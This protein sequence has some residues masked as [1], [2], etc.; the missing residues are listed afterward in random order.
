MLRNKL[1]ASPVYAGILIGLC[2]SGSPH[3]VGSSAVP[4]KH[5]ATAAYRQF[6]FFIG[7]WETYDVTDSVKSV[8]RNHVSRM[9]DGC[10]VR[11]VYTQ[12]DGLQGESFSTYDSSRRLWHQSWV[13]NHGSL[14]LMD[15]GLNGANM[16]FTGTV[17][18]SAGSK[19]LIR[20][21][22]FPK[23]GSVRETAVRS[24][25]NGKSWQPV[26]DIVFRPHSRLNSH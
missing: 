17:V 11:E 19:S 4:T 10:A 24:T 20:V 26:F 22:W 7:D 23:H 3:R 6:D 25:D 1:L 15:G 8:A 13:T 14:L 12:Y 21:T 18:D 9:L 2:G 5:C 16:V